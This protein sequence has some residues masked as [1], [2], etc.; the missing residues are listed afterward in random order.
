MHWISRLFRARQ[1]PTECEPRPTPA[2]C[3]HVPL[4]H[5]ALI[6]GCE[7]SE[8][9]QESPERGAGVVIELCQDGLDLHVRSSQLARHVLHHQPADLPE[10]YAV[11][12]AVLHGFVEGG[13]GD[14]GMRRLRQHGLKVLPVARPLLDRV[15][16]RV[17]GAAIVVRASGAGVGHTSMLI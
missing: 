9:V 15:L 2:A 5:V 16:Q 6:V 11:L 10:Y 12:W 14:H 1:R 13:A 17:L 7:C 3:P 8:I 4:R